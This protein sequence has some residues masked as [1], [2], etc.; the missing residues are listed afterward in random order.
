MIKIGSISIYP[1]AS[2][3][4][5]WGHLCIDLN[6]NWYKSSGFYSF[7]ENSKRFESQNSQKLCIGFLINNTIMFQI[8]YLIGIQKN[9]SADTCDFHTINVY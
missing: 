5:V 1:N 7:S 8:W 3:I 6:W 4:Y 9:D 2:R